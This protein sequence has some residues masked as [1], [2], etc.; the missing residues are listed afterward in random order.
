MNVKKLILIGL[1]LIGLPFIAGAQSNTIIDNL[2]EEKKA[3]WGKTVYMVFTAADLAE[4]N[5][6][7][8]EI[9]E[10]LSRNQLGIDPGS[11]EE[12]ITLGKYSFLLMKAFDIPGGLMYKLFPGSRYAVRELSY[13]NFIDNDKSPYRTLSGEEVLRILG[14]VL[15]WKEEQK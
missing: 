10:S 8:S 4:E 7:I 5:S 15:E 13:L 9:M 11:P 3:D 6:E 1:V 14:R 2:L 12:A